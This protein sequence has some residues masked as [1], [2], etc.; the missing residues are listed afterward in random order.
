MPIYWIWVCR[1]PSV[2]TRR[3]TFVTSTW[4]EVHSSSSTGLFEIQS[5]LEYE[6][7]CQLLW[8]QGLSPRKLG[9]LWYW[10]VQWCRSVTQTWGLLPFPATPLPA[11]H[12]HS[13][14]FDAVFLW[15]QSLSFPPHPHSG[16]TCLCNLYLYQVMKA[17]KKC[18]LSFSGSHKP[19]HLYNN[20]KWEPCRAQVSLP[21]KGVGGLSGY[22]SL[23]PLVTFHTSPEFSWFLI[24]P[25][26]VHGQAVPSRGRYQR[27]CEG[28]PDEPSFS[29]PES[30]EHLH[31]NSKT[32]K[33]QMMLS[34]CF[35]LSDPKQVS[36]HHLL[37]SF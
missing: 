33:T 19:A 34:Y 29:K 8:K 25:A 16:F 4:W 11:L 3:Q 28:L 1:R 31:A 24:T 12:T 9:S 32:E 23:S 13:L 10:T 26:I 14:S 5:L 20:I 27:D 22:M 18:K 21:P 35:Q 2:S 7:H 17:E 37:L 36:W 15:L 6:G 30:K